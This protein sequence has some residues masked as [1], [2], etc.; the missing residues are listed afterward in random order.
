MPKLTLYFPKTFE[1]FAWAGSSFCLEAPDDP[2]HHRAGEWVLGR[3][4]ASDLTLSVRS[5][6]TKHCAIT[7]SYAAD[8]WSVQDLG[9][10]NGT[11]LNGKL[12][13]PKDLA[14][15]AIG[16]RLHLGP[17]LV[18]VV[19]HEQSTEQIDGATTIAGLTPLDHRTGAPLGEQPPA[20]PAGASSP[21]T[22]APPLVPAH[23]KTYA[24]SLDTGLEW[25]LN[26]RTTLGTLVRLLVV[27]LASAVVVLVMG[28]I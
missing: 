22:P 26:P 16:D 11:R 7:Y 13:G 3:H 21:P 17:S 25:L 6:S 19:E 4:P 28:A 27:V 9:S 5:I 14:P 23:P 10:T 2:G 24:D 20:A 8:Q 12:L 18:Q 1:D 15:L